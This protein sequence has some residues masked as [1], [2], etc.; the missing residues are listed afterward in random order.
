MRF[1]ALFFAS[2]ALAACASGGIKYRVEKQNAITKEKTLLAS[3][4]DSV[5]T[6]AMGGAWCS[7]FAERAIAQCVEHGNQAI[8]EKELRDIRKTHELAR[9]GDS[10]SQQ[11]LGYMYYHGMLV[12]QD[13]KESI[14]WNMA[15]SEKNM[16]AQ[17][18][19]GVIHF[20]GQG[21]PKNIDKS[22]YWFERAKKSGHPDADQAIA[23]I[24]RYQ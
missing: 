7:Y 21:T 4:C 17:F 6:D 8:F 24:K 16:H 3:G 11:K 20:N 5:C 15:A 9:Q 13:Y 12:K 14:K 22:L 10:F 23:G 1:L 2:I 18:A 19:L